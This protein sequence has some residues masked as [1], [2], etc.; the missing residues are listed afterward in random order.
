MPVLRMMGAASGALKYFTSAFA[1]SGAAAFLS[2]A[3]E[4]TV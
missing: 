2:T 4:K 3:A 1:A